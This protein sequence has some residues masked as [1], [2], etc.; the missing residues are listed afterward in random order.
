MPDVVRGPA[1][2]RA[3]ATRFFQAGQPLP[4]QEGALPV[5][6]AIPLALV[7]FGDAGDGA[8]GELGQES[9]RGER[10]KSQKGPTH[11]V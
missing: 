4:F 7:E 6:Q 2:L 11:Q 1:S 8:E 5:G 10:K 9:R 3:G